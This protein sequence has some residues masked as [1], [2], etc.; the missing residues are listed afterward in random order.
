MVA[1]SLCYI[2]AHGCETPFLSRNSL[3]E[4][5]NG[6]VLPGHRLCDEGPTTLR[7]YSKVHVHIYRMIL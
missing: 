2:S 3:E 5:L 6:T 4:Y 1:T 7:A